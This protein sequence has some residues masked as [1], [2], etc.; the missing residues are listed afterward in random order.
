MTNQ[1]SC[2]AAG[3]D[4]HIAKPLKA[5]VLEDTLAGISIS[6]AKIGGPGTEYP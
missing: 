5:H 3:M 2:L 1:E 4:G 6:S